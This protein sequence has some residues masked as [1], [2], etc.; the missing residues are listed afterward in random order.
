[1]IRCLLPLVFLVGCGQVSGKPVPMERGAGHPFV[2]VEID[3]V[4][5]RCMVDTGADVLYV[6][7][8]LA[9]Q[10]PEGVL[11]YVDRID[12]GPVTQHNVPTVVLDQERFNEI[13]RTVP[14]Q[15]D[16]LL[17]FTVLPE[18][19]IIDYA[20]QTLWSGPSPLWEPENTVE[21]MEMD[22]VLVW[23]FP[24]GRATFGDAEPVT[25]LL[26]T[27]SP[28]S[29]LRP[30]VFDTLSDPPGKTPASVVTEEGTIEA[31][32]AD[33]PISVKEEPGVT[34]EV[35]VYDSPE[36][37]Y[38]EDALFIDLDAVL[39]VEYLLQH[40]LYW[41]QFR[42]ELILYRYSREIRDELMAEYE[43]HLENP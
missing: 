6:V 29:V 36:L 37:D 8:W 1:M 13:G 3:E 11:F 14:G 9:P 28:F 25:A 12:Y 7:P 26:N 4:G 38:L 5:V 33:L 18:T 41:D 19:G 20:A 2:E 21:R 27:S 35:L 42:D 23:P 32:F 16:C 24:M 30:W 39:G 43:E 22:T 15:V 10:Q 31:Y 34:V 40:A 17:G